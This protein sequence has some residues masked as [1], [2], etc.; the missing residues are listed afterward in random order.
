MLIVAVPKSASSSL[1]TTLCE[2][3]GK[4]RASPDI[5]RRHLR[6]APAAAGFACLRRFNRELVEVP[7]A[8]LAALAARDTVQ[9]HHIAPT[10]HNRALLRGV[11]K[12][13]LLRPGEEVAA[14]YWRGYAT[15]TWTSDV[16][17]ITRCAS[18]AEWLAVARDMGLVAEVEAFNAGW[19]EAGDG[20]VITHAELTADSR[21][22]L[23]RV[24]AHFGESAARIP[25]LARVNFTRDG[26][27]GM[28]GWRRL[29]WA[30][31]AWRARF[32][33]SAR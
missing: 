30:A 33:G 24:L 27:A 25:E 19:R 1:V 13:I 11:P 32:L 17:E 7:P 29:M 2:A 20:L 9:K 14:A 16:T 6:D 26:G 22:T 28:P 18:E 10:A 23:A 3:T 8:A 21:G 5:R 12:V 15:S 31:R 4:R